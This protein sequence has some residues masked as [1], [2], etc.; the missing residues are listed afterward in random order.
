MFI[1]LHKADATQRLV[2]GR[3]DETPDRVGEIF[4][5]ASSR[6][7]I[8]KWS[9]DLAKASGGKSLGNIRVMHQLKAAGVLTG[10]YFDDA[11]RAIEFCAHIIDD[12]EWQ[13]I[14]AGVYTGFSPGGRKRFLDQT[15]T[16]YTAFPSEISLVDL[17]C[18]PSAT[19][20]LVKAE[21]AVE[22]RFA[23][24]EQTDRE[25]LEDLAA[26][27]TRSDYRGR[28]LALPADRL[29]KLFGHDPEAAPGHLEKRDW[30]APE[31]RKAASEGTAMPDGGYPIETKGDLADAVK[32]WKRTG[33]GTD[34]QTH[35]IQRARAIGAADN[36]PK[37]WTGET[38]G[39][40]DPDDLTALAADFKRS[41]DAATAQRVHDLACRH[42]AV[43]AAGSHAG[44]AKIAGDLAAAREDL[45]KEAAENA[46]LRRRVSQL[47]QLPAGGG[48]RLRAIGR[49]DQPDGPTGELAALASLPAAT[50]AE[51]LAKATAITR[52]ALNHPNQA[53]K[54]NPHE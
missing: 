28:I 47:E 1:P 14:E 30:S 52:L 17:P 37:D 22:H 15:R 21:G 8:E 19:F 42:G 46:T 41:G 34:A 27:T 24:R 11:A 51:Q 44:L 6:P 16:R 2:Y 13:K 32:A 18:I 38:G 25:V 29:E 49:G 9:A 36:L 10:L 20:T 39:A 40:A 53:L 54:G 33:G 43:C 50:Q 35:I 12:E 5:Y 26:S 31:R 4:D 7:E 23:S 48:P 3:L 45:S